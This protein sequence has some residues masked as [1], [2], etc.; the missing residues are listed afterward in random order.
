MTTFSQEQSAIF[1]QVRFTSKRR[2]GL[3]TEI[4]QQHAE[5][6]KRQAKVQTIAHRTARMHDDLV[7]KQKQVAK[8]QEKVARE[9]AE[10]AYE[11]EV[12]AKEQADISREQDELTQEQAEI[13]QVQTEIAKGQEEILREQA[14]IL[15]VNGTIT[16]LSTVDAGL[17]TD[18]V[19]SL[20]QLDKDG[21]LKP[22]LLDCDDAHKTIFW[23]T[24]GSVRLTKTQYDIVTTLYHAPACQMSITDVEERAWGENMMPTTNAAAVAVSRLNAELKVANFPFEVIRIKRKVKTGQVVNPETKMPMEVLVQPEIEVYELVRI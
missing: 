21:A 20:D 23:G 3:A 16:E 24:N 17:Q 9:E 11:Q 15:K 4:A 1:N 12:I 8:K 2:K 13:I 19:D 7:K 22:V 5:V 6:E 18:V 10:I 14:E